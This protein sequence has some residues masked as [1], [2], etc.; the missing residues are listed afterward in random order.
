M[1]KYPA[2]I[3]VLLFVFISSFKCKECADIPSTQLDDSRNWFPLKGKTVL[4]YVTDNG[5][6]RQFPALVID[7]T[8][9]FNLCNNGLGSS[10]S[11]ESI[12]VQLFLDSI[13]GTPGNTQFITSELSRVNELNVVATTTSPAVPHDRWNNIFS[14]AGNDQNIIPL[15]NYRLNNTT[16]PQVILLKS[17]NLN[18]LIDSIF[19]AKNHGIVGFKYKGVKYALQ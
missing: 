18:P 11:E 8:I 19:L 17:A 7:T 9:Q 10:F 15:N 14:R 5:T 3:V 2:L 13:T 6:P 12:R 4:N 1:K 16:Y